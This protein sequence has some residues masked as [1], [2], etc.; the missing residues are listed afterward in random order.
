[1]EEVE[2]ESERLGRELALWRRLRNEARALASE[3]D[4]LDVQHTLLRLQTSIMG[5]LNVSNE[6]SPP[7]I[8]DFTAAMPGGDGGDNVPKITAPEPLGWR[9][10]SLSLKSVP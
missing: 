6:S 5:S 2:F 1:M 9:S 7:K 4:D 8:V 10:R 3:Q